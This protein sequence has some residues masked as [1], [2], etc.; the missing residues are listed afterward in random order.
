M[1]QIYLPVACMHVP[2]DSRTDLVVFIL[3][4]SSSLCAC[5][6]ILNVFSCACTHEEKTCLVD[7]KQDW[8]SIIQAL[9][10]LLIIY[11]LLF[12][13]SSFY[14]KSRSI[15]RQH[16]I[17]SSTAKV[18]DLIWCNY[19]ID[20]VTCFLELGHSAALGQ[21]QTARNIFSLCVG[22]FWLLFCVRL[23]ITSTVA[24][25]GEYVPSTHW[26]NRIL[27]GYISN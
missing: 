4:H 3:L 12:K 18:S 24:K 14:D 22:Q 21:S 6:Q 19:F 17:T 10:F 20:I 11:A 15:S 9:L 26:P 25:I 5:T 2:K 23:I 16:Y 13:I 8:K 27:I 7:I 1:Y